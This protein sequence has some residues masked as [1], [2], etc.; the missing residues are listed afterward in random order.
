MERVTKE[1]VK[2]FLGGEKTIAH[3]ETDGTWSEL[4]YIAPCPTNEEYIIVF[5][6]HTKKPMSLWSGQLTMWNYYINYTKKDLYEHSIKIY[7]S[8]IAR[9]KEMIEKEESNKK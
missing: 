7:E 5:D 4:K 2:D 1:N 9:L 3:Y 8:R 6:M